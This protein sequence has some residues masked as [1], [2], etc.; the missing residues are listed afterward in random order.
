MDSIDLDTSIGNR[1]FKPHSSRPDAVKSVGTVI[2]TSKGPIEPVPLKLAASFKRPMLNVIYKEKKT[3]KIKRRKIPLRDLIH[4]DMSIRSSIDVT[5]KQIVEGLR[6]NNEILKFVSTEKVESLVNRVIEFNHISL[7]PTKSANITPSSVFREKPNNSMIPKPSSA[8][9]LPALPIK[10]VPSPSSSPVGSL[11]S[12][13]ERSSL[14]LPVSRDRSA[15]RKIDGNRD[16]NKLGDDELMEV[17]RAMDKDFERT[18]LKPGDPGYQYEKTF[19]RATESNEWDEESDAVSQ[20]KSTASSTKAPMSVSGTT[21]D[22]EE[23]SPVIRPRALGQI[24]TVALENAPTAKD[25]NSGRIGEIETD[26]EIDEILEQ[27]DETSGVEVRERTRVGVTAKLPSADD[28]DARAPRSSLPARTLSSSLSADLVAPLP[29]ALLLRTPSS[30]PSSRHRRVS[31]SSRDQ[32]VLFADSLEE[33]GSVEDERVLVKR[34]GIPPG[35]ATHFVDKP[36][37]SDLEVGSTDAVNLENDHGQ[38]IKQTI[39]MRSEGTTSPTIVLQSD[40]CLEEDDQL[41]ELGSRVIRERRHSHDSSTSEDDEGSVCSEG[42]GEESVFLDRHVSAPSL[43]GTGGM[44]KRRSLD[45][46]SASASG[47]GGF[48]TVGGKAQP[49]M[50][51][52][53]SVTSEAEN[54]TSSF[55][56]NEQK[57]E[58]ST[59]EDEKSSHSSSIPVASSVNRSLGSLNKNSTGLSNNPTEGSSNRSLD[60]LNKPAP[61]SSKVLEGIKDAAKPSSS[62]GSLGN[63]STPIA[64]Q[65]RDARSHLKSAAEATKAED[66]SDKKSEAEPKP[67]AQVEPKSKPERKDEVKI[68]PKKEVSELLSE[69]DEIE[70][71]VDFEEE[72]VDDLLEEATTKPDPIPTTTPSWLTRNDLPDVSSRGNRMGLAP[73]GGSLAPLGRLEDSKSANSLAPVI[74]PLIPPKPALGEEKVADSQAPIS[75][76][77]APPTQPSTAVAPTPNPVALPPKPV[78]NLSSIASKVVD[79]EKSKEAEKIDNEEKSEKKGNSVLE[80]VEYE[81]EDFEFE[82][83]ELDDNG[84]NFFDLPVPKTTVPEIKVEKEEPKVEEKKLEQLKTEQ[85]VADKP[86]KPSFLIDP[87]KPSAIAAPIDASKPS[88]LLG[89]LPPLGGTGSNSNLPTIGSLSRSFNAL[90]APKPTLASIP[91]TTAAGDVAKS[92]VEAKPAEKPNENVSDNISED[93]SEDFDVDGILGSDDEDVGAIKSSAR[94]SA[95]L[96]ALRDAFKASETYVKTDSSK[97]QEQVEEKKGE[98]EMKEEVSESRNKYLKTPSSSSLPVPAVASPAPVAAAPRAPSPEFD[99]GAGDTDAEDESSVSLPSSGGWAQGKGLGFGNSSFLKLPAVD[100]DVE[101]ELDEVSFEVDGGDGDGGV[102]GEDDMF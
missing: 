33:L 1:S 36:P 85:K 64:K 4:E 78:F 8:G 75:A 61:V 17:K 67:P 44:R 16:L 51:S 97:I 2:L 93:I 37:K 24:G 102:V 22:K 42:S 59:S 83:E 86:E 101:I 7:V 29:M 92:P 26:D 25:T 62:L 58:K 32:K 49:T 27:E 11:T 10:L 72:D 15:E 65:I 28:E 91:A 19:E 87:P 63:M 74:G 50:E 82:E 100:D 48:L 23:T 46:T 68:E 9:P 14:P 53:L 21:K 13:V 66:N 80:D 99:F 76:P 94:S 98:V 73:L 84:Y 77:L 20:P 79:S 34:S 3:G 5:S 81:D 96:S 55:K 12:L 70:E 40:E 18:L 54:N 69:G 90:D 47:A 41:P 39:L 52:I 31:V 45:A 57:T 71:E 88:S 38:K 43:L 56:I 35:L 95:G 60:S 30:P 6:E 89:A